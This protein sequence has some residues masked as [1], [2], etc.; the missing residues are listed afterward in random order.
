V[1]KKSVE[2]AGCPHARSLGLPLTVVILSDLLLV[3][4]LGVEDDIRKEVQEDVFE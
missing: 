1:T 2:A 3:L 4:T